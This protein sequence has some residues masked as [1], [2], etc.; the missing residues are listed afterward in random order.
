MSDDSMIRL[1]IGVAVKV[2]PKGVLLVA[3]TMTEK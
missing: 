2:V 1:S 3:Q